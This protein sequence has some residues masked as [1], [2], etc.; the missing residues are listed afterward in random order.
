MRRGTSWAYALLRSLRRPVDLLDEYERMLL[1]TIP[2]CIGAIFDELPPSYSVSTRHPL[3]G[4]FV[5]LFEP[6]I[7]HLAT[8]EDIRRLKLGPIE[9]TTGGEALV[10]L[11]MLFL[12]Y[13][14]SAFYY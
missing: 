2:E 4:F 9:Y 5:F 7:I 14:G 3:N 10:D 13:W 6:Q 8:D 1:N 12:Y 11:F